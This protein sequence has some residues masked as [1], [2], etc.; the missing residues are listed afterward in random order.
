[1]RGE[2]RNEGSLVV[3]SFEGVLE[4]GAFL[5]AR[6]RGDP[7]LRPSF[8]VTPGGRRVGVDLRVGA[9]AVEREQFGTLPDGR[10][11]RAAESP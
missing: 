10:A 2:A 3:V 9:G 11:A 7:K 6:K 1:M 5:V 8:P 4:N